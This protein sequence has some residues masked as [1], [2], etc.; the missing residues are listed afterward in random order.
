MSNP[1]KAF[2]AASTPAAAIIVVT[3]PSITPRRPTR[4]AMTGTESNAA[5]VP[6]AKIA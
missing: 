5:I 2:H 6:A 3:A 1:G 4:G